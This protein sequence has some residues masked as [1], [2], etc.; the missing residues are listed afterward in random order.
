M[1]PEEGNPFTL[2]TPERHS[3]RQGTA[4]QIGTAK[5]DPWGKSSHTIG[6]GLF[7]RNP[8]ICVRLADTTSQRSESSVSRP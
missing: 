7:G 2:R 5:F 3:G 8:P 1:P 6:T 4:Y